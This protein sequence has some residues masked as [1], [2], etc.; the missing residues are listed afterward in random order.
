MRKGNLGIYIQLLYIYIDYLFIEVEES[1]QYH[2]ST[3]FYMI[4]Q[5]LIEILNDNISG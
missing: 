2:D 1:M 5:Y 3:R 4:L